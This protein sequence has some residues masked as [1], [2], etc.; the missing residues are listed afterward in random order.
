MT[1]TCYRIIEISGSENR[2]R[3]QQRKCAIPDTEKPVSHELEKVY[4][5]FRQWT[6]NEMASQS[7]LAKCQALRKGPLN[8]IS[9]SF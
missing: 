7:S 4:V 2:I 1:P 3:L 6:R 9:V 8:S 5:V